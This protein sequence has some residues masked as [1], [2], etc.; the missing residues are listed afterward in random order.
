[1]DAITN[2][3]PSVTGHLVSGVEECAQRCVEVLDDPI[4]A[5]VMALR[6]KEHVRR[7]FLTPRLVLDWLRLAEALRDGVPYASL[8]AGHR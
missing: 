4:A 5:A 1:L 3:S 8:A 6:G 2:R 7:H